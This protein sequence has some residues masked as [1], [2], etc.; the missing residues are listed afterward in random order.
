MS[1]H[2]IFAPCCFAEVLVPVFIFLVQYGYMPP[3]F[4][5]AVILP[6]PKG[7]NTDLSQSANYRGI[8][9]APCFSKAQSQV[10]LLIA[11]STLKQAIFDQTRQ[12][13]YQAVAFSVYTF[14]VFFWLFFL[15]RV[16]LKISVGVCDFATC[17]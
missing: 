11:L 1:D 15:K 17:M 9:L 14:T 13:G 5:D 7:G 16:F 10:S 6:I 2:L 12:I 4:R 3:V 8:A